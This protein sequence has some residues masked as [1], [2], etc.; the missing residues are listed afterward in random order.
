LY[1]KNTVG[2]RKSSRKG[3]E[4]MVSQ[5]TFIKLAKHKPEL[6]V[7][8]GATRLEK[9]PRT[10]IYFDGHY[11]FKTLVRFRKERQFLEKIEQER[12]RSG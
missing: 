11:S 2:N 4:Q 12:R 3:I 7:H 9:P 1:N 10:E 6:K 8:V 5:K